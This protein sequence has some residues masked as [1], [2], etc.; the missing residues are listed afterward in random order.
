MA[1]AE[2]AIQCLNDLVLR[3]SRVLIEK[4][5]SVQHRT[6]NAVAALYRL[7]VDERLLY[8][9]ELVDRAQ[10]LDRGDRPVRRFRNRRL[11]GPNR[12]P[13][14]EDSAGPALRKAA[15]ELRPIQLKII[16]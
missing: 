2:Q 7:L 9:M 1:A 6:A 15:A 14:K 12:L 3:R 10:S 11:A 16:H 5:F 8:G 13:I 4:H